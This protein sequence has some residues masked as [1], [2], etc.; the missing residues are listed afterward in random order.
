MLR[1]FKAVDRAIGRIM[2]F[3]PDADIVLFS[4][5]GMQAN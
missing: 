5:E 3:R 2:T 4:P 1:V